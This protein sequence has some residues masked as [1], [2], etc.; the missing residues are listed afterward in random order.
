MSNKESVKLI[1]CYAKFP[2]AGDFF[3]KRMGEITAEYV[4]DIMWPRPP[5]DQLRVSFPEYF[6]YFR[7]MLP[8]YNRELESKGLKPMVLDYEFSIRDSH[9]IFGSRLDEMTEKTLVD[10]SKKYSHEIPEI[11]RYV[12]DVRD[13]I[14]NEKRQAKSGKPKYRR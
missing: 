7:R 13:R 12:S 2:I 5:M 11:A 1:T 8:R 6:E 4:A 10:L 3:G 9:V 14:M